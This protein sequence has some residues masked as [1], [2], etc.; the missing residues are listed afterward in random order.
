MAGQEGFEPPTLGFGDRCSTS[1][2]Y[3]PSDRSSSASRRPGFTLTHNNSGT[4]RL[5]RLA[6]RGVPPAAPAVLLEFEA[7]RG[8]LLVL[9][10]RIVSPLAR[11]AC[12]GHNHAHSIHSVRSIHIR[13]WPEGYSLM[14]VITPAPT[15]RPPSRIAKRSSFSIAIGMI[16]STSTDTLSPG[17]TISTPS[18][19]LTT[20]VTSV[21]R[22]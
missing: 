6:M 20:P 15:V 16:N 22:K 10:R 19:R 17:I 8:L 13:R 9:R 5:L 7:V 12:Q 21:V 14:S 3:W 2:S 1:S 11:F 4:G 18:G